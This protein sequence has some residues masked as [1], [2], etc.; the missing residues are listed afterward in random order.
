MTKKIVFFILFLNVI[1]SSYAQ[2]IKLMSYNIRYDNPKDGENA[3]PNRKET[4]LNQILFYEPDILGVQE[5]LAHQLKYLDNGLKDYAYVGVGR[6]D[7]KEKGKGE[8]S[9][10]F[11]NHAKFTKLKSGTFW[12]SKTPDKPSRGWDASLNRICTFILLENK[13]SG[14]KFWVFNTHF[15]HKGVTARKKSAELIIKKIKQ[16]N[17]QNFPVFLMGDFNLKPE[18]LPIRYIASKLNDSKSV[19][20]QFSYGPQETFNGFKVCEN[21]NKRIDYI[22]VSKENIKV[23][24]YVVIA[25]LNDQRF[26][27]DHFPVFISAEMLK[28]D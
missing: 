18:E 2:D 24:K 11:F 12:L 8:F 9:A 10:I 13:K 16:K 28:N 26:P 14:I 3:W 4:L 17:K 6:A 22:F 15:D 19:Y 7:V 21:P 1:T 25:D 27:S 23:K 20:Q 5:A